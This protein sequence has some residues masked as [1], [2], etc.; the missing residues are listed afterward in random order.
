MSE[1]MTEQGQ[2]QAQVHP[3]WEPFLKD[4][5][6]VAGKHNLVALGVA[7]VFATKESEE[8]TRLN[9]HSRMVMPDG[10]PATDAQNLAVA[11]AQGVNGAAAQEAARVAGLGVVRA[12]AETKAAPAEEKPAA[13]A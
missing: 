10:M 2:G 4:V 6:E 12:L 8:Q 7:G 3:G 1:T 11:L 13:D 5:M 9:L